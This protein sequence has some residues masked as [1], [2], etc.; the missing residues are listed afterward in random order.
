MVLLGTTPPPVS[1]VLVTG[2]R[3]FIGSVLTRR[4]LDAGHQVLVVDNGDDLRQRRAVAGLAGARFVDAD[5]RTCDLLTMLDGIDR[6]VHLAG[7]PGVQT[8]WGNGF[9]G[10]LEDNAGMTQRLLEA[11]LDV[12]VRSI[13]VASSSSVYGDVRY[14]F[15]T[16]ERPVAPLSPYGVSKAAVELLVRAYAARGVPAVALRF[17]SVYGRGQRPD[18]ALARI[19]DSISGGEPFPLRGSGEAMRD[20]T[21]VDD[22]SAATQA[23]LFADL[24][25]GAICNVGTGAPVS[26]ATMI[27]TVSRHFGRPVP[28]V[29]QP[30]AAGDP[31]RTAADRSLARRLLQ[32]EPTVSLA[33]GI[34]D[35]IAHHHSFAVAH[36]DLVT[37]SGGADVFAGAASSLRATP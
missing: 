29:S 22:V 18:M 7:K 1:N 19:I 27:E 10:H 26:V 11:A 25:P 8:S 37:H 2:G 12:D 28:V 5:L 16:E 3:G 24:A 6:V 13:V 32:W 17:F 9:R 34:A 35:Q 36:G 20:L 31:G 15:A 33:D 21:H 4:L 23:A 30:E 14:G